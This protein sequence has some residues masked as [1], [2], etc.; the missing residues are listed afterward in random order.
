MSRQSTGS[1]P[2]S[3]LLSQ[4]FGISTTTAETETWRHFPMYAGLGGRSSYHSRHCGP[5]WTARTRT[6]LAP[7]SN[8]QSLFPS[9]Y[10]CT[11]TIASLPTTPSPRSSPALLDDSDPCPLGERLNTYK[12]SPLTYL[13][14]LLLGTYLYV[15][16][17]ITTRVVTQRSHPHL[18]T[19]DLSSLRSLRSESFRTKLP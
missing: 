17:I 16:A 11:R 9:A 13:V 3:S 15:V 7:T 5:I 19:G 2:K 1:L 14:P 8:A 18:F 12:A 4:T 10:H 6:K